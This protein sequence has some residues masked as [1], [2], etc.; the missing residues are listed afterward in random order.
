MQIDAYA[1]A[2]AE[3]EICRVVG[4]AVIDAA[5]QQGEADPGGRQLVIVAVGVV[6]F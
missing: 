3:F 5:G 6:Y 1:L 4:N 2:E